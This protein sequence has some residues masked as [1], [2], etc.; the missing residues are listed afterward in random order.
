MIGIRFC[1]AWAHTANG[2]TIAPP[3]RSEMK[4]RRRMS[5]S[6]LRTRHRTGQT[7][8]LE[9]ACCKCSRC[10]LWVKSR[11]VRRTSPCPLYPPCGHVQCNS[12]CP[13]SANSGHSVI[14]SNTS[15]ARPDR[16]SGTV[17]P[18]ALAVLRFRKS[19]TFVDCWTG[20]SA[21]L[22][23]LRTRPV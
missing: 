13:L 9:I 2:N 8:T 20:R 6:R 11:H 23:P 7:T 1:C 16:G 4:S 10:P 12:G 3:P 22:F 14:H 17:I 18:S 5:A 15:S 19:S 21:G